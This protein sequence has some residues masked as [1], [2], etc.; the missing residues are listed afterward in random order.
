MS[1]GVVTNVSLILGFAGAHPAASVVRLAGLAGLVAGAFS[2]AAGEFVSMSAQRELFQ[3]ELDV[4]RRALRDTPE[5]ETEELIAI[6]EK[7]GLAPDF[8]R[9]FAAEVMSDP[10]LALETHAR[11]EF[12]VDPAALGSPTRAALASFLAFTVGASLPLLPW[13]FGGGAAAIIASIVL[14][15]LAAASLG[16]LL[17]HITGRAWWKGALRSLA[18][19]T[20][21]AG[22]TFAIG[23]AV[24]T[25]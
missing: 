1:D 23:R 25:S 11:E 17:A 8:A 16:G 20:L 22:V 12:G 19:A 21:A 24:G 2:M 14:S 7:K 3:H 4:E 15:G 5:G 13:L 6:F 9:R 10:E 18:L